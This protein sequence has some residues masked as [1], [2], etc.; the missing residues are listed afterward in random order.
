MQWSDVR[1]VYPGQW[2]VIEALEAHSENRRRVL[3]RIVVVE[4]CPDGSS[5][6][7]RYRELSGQHPGR[8][9]YFVHTANAELDILE[10]PWVGI[11][12]N[13]APHDS[14]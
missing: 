14:R 3:D 6:L 5:A 10:R 8:E 13:D 9:L 7:R 11:R 1:P 12:R 2:L 4:V